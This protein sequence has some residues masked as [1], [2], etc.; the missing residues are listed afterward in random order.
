MEI[1]LENLKI[2]E[3]VNVDSSDS[4]V[5]DTKS[6]ASIADSEGEVNNKEINIIHSSFQNSTINKLDHDL[7]RVDRHYYKRPTQLMF[8]LKK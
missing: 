2:V 7:R 3:V 8:C 5:S 4:T 6:E 1:H